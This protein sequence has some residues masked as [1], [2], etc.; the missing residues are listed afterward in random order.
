[1]RNIL[2][3]P[4]MTE[5]IAPHHMF[6]TAGTA[7]GGNI[8]LLL[9]EEECSAYL[10]TAR[11]LR[12]PHRFPRRSWRENFPRHGHGQVFQ[13]RQYA[14]EVNLGLVRMADAGRRGASLGFAD[15]GKFNSEFPPT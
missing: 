2:E 8:S 11:F 1:M 15:G 14:P 4:F 3:A 9:S 7:N 13:E 5:M 10:D 6:T 12:H